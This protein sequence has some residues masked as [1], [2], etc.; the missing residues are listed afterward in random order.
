MTDLN[1]LSA[2]VLAQMIREG[3]VK[4]SEVMAA[5]LARIAEREPAVGAFQYLDAE[6]AMDRARQADLCPV[7]GPMYGVPCPNFFEQ[8]RNLARR[9]TCTN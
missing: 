2:H 3:E 4:P 9:I 1:G 7:N 6:R 5:H 8:Q